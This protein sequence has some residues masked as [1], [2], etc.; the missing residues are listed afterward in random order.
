MELII[1]IDPRASVAAVRTPV[2]ETSRS[3]ELPAPSGSKRISYRVKPG[4]T[5]AAIATQFGTS[6]QALQSWNGIRGS[7]IVAGDNLT[8]YA[9]RGF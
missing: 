8:V 7:R 2:A 1:P 4:D 6:I 5:L 9:T 3:A